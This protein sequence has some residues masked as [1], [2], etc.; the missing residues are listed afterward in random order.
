MSTE[1]F[2]TKILRATRQHLREG[3]QISHPAAPTYHPGE[4]MNKLLGMV[5]NTEEVELSCDEVFEILD[6]NVELEARGEDVST[7]LPLVKSHLDLCRDC[8]EEYEA[9]A[10]VFEA[11]S[12]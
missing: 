6:Q 5:E 2:L 10:K 8:H 7:L 12:L 3:K 4:M 11:T 1:N 9:L